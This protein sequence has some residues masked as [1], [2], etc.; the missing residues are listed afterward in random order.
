[1]VSSVSKQLAGRLVV[2]DLSFTLS[3]GETLGL[4]GPNGSGKTTTIRM[5]LDILRPDSG[6]IRVFGDPP[7]TRLSDRIGYLPEER[8][9][10]RSMTISRT[11]IYLAAL[12]DMPERRAW[13][14]IERLL[15]RVGLW[16]H[17]NTKVGELSRGMSQL[18]G[19]CAAIQHQPELLI[20]DEP[21]SGLDPV[22]V[23]IMKDLISEVSDGGTAVVFSTHQM[24]DV[25]ALCER[26][27]MMKLGASVLYG[28]LSEI[29][30]HHQTNAIVVDF[31]GRLSS[32]TGVERVVPKGEGS[33]ELVLEPGADAHEV[34]RALANDGIRLTRFQLIVPTLNEIFLQLAVNEPNRGVD[35]GGGTR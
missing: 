22:N 4:V 27:L 26:V 23:K 9:L 19:F 24:E 29:K 1:M 32:I 2:R 3:A 8:G 34:L 17:R 10:Y 16:Q 35:S 15:K 7:S 20:L 33:A 5:L 14:Q 25:E 28:R 31:E 30:A 12:K 18:I 13:P 11:L 6:E 21:F